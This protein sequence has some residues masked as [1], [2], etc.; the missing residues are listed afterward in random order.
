MTAPR[1]ST[2]LRAEVER[3]S[4]TLLAWLSL[5]PRPLLPAVVLVLLLAS[6]VLPVALAA[7]CLVLVLLVV[8]WLSY[9]SWPLLQPRA[10]VL[11]LL[12]LVLL[13]FLGGS[14]LLAQ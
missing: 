13:V 11:R 12:V 7:V 8:G 6:A 9:L 5:R 1:P 14:R 10:K 4:G 2:G 3:R